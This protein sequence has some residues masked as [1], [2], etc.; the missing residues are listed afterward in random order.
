MSATPQGRQEY[1]GWYPDEYAE[2]RT[3]AYAPDAHPQQMPEYSG[4]QDYAPDYGQGVQH[5]YDIP[6]QYAGEAQAYA[7]AEPAYP[8]A[9]ADP[10]YGSYA[11][12][13]HA[14]VPGQGYA[15]T[16]YADG[17]FADSAYVDYADPGYSDPGYADYA[18]N[19][20]YPGADHA[21]VAHT[22][23]DFHIRPDTDRDYAD[24]DYVD[25]DYADRDYADPGDRPHTH[26]HPDPAS[27]PDPAAQ[28]SPSR[29]APRVPIWHPPGLVPALL[30]TGVAVVLS[31]SALAGGGAAVAGVL[32]LQVL[33]A[34]GWFRLHGMWPAR[35]GI[36]LAVAAGGGAD[37]AVLL[38][39]DDALAILPGVLA[40]VL[41]V[42]LLQQLV[43]RDGRPE[44]MPALTVTASAA[45]L[46]VLDVMF[47]LAARV[48]GP[49]VRD[50]ALVVLGAAAVAAAVLPASL[51]LPGPVGTVIGLAA[52]AGVGAAA[53]SA[54]H[55]QSTAVVLGI[56]AGTMGLLG[57]RAA[58]YDHP[59]RF[60]H[61]TAGV[62]LPLAVAA[63]AV[64][65]LGRVAMG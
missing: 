59:S 13:A 62:A 60:V 44:L 27:D 7:P 36:A 3:E 19:T 39:G 4:A 31:V 30:T 42:A 49:G 61:M 56:G 64:Y 33:T 46:T 9:P 58:G 55:L 45:L 20:G 53:G 41:A 23:A 24:P 5:G 12:P 18:S 37:A 43:R 17:G 40:A 25:P 51:P 35:Q 63:P 2:G 6:A 52:A 28:R 48:E 15:G 1:G 21:E 34:A 26:D 47:V 50:G 65:L 29:V 10:A 22:E 16:G 8:G 54:L 14:A 11:D 32:L 38:A 57:R